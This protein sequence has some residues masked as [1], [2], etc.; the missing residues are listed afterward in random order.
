MQLLRRWL[1]RSIAL[2]RLCAVQTRAIS[3]VHVLRSEVERMFG[4][5]LCWQGLVKM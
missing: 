4:M 5:W 1:S 2:P 3:T